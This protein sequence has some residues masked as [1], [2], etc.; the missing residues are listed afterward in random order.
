[1]TNYISIGID[2]GTSYSS[3]AVYMNGTLKN[4]PTKQGEITIPSYVSFTDEEILI[5]N[6][7][8]NQASDNPSNTV[9]NIKRIIGL[10]YNDKSVQNS[11][12]NFPFKINNNDGKPVIQVEYKTKLKNF[13][14]EEITS[15]L[16]AELKENAEYCLDKKVSQAA[17]T[18]PDYFSNSQRQATIKASKMAGF[19]NIHIINEST[20][21]AIPYFLNNTNADEKILVFNL[22]SDTFDVSTLSINNNKLKFLA[23]SINAFL[24]GKK[25]DSLVTEYLEKK[26]DR[27]HAINIPIDSKD[28]SKLNQQS[29]KAKASLSSQKSINNLIDSFFR[30]EGF[31]EI[32]SQSELETLNTNLFKM[33]SEFVQNVLNDS[34]LNR[35]DIDEIILTGCSTRIPKISKILEELF[36]GKKVS[37]ETG[38]STS[39]VYGAAVQ[40]AIIDNDEGLKNLSIIGATSKSIGIESQNSYMEIII[41]RNTEVPTKRSIVYS[42]A[43]D[44]QEAISINIFEGERA[45]IKDNH[46]LG[47]YEVTEIPLSP[48]GVPQI[49]V[50]FKVDANGILEISA[51]DKATSKALPIINIDDQ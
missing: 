15:M 8:K 7:A 4:I 50:T 19:S 31:S 22:D 24:S 41:S 13:T 2:L 44:N 35:S 36:S 42:T 12:K 10:K 14:P 47:N 9:F 45:F 33:I 49:E 27:K 46:L 18:V 17:I 48:S 34:N 29:E 23:S 1:M 26:F 28:M 51:E 3:A 6:S 25:F 43:T 38:F 32:L 16:L 11:I 37:A 5:G 39:A 21:A 40:A 20:A 30:D